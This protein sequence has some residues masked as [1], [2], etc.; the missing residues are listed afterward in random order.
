MNASFNTISQIP[1]ELPLRLPHLS[2][3]D[4]SY[5][6]I[7]CLPESFGLLLHLKILNIKHNKLQG[8]PES[9]VNLIKL[10]KMDLSH[11]H[12]Q[13]L[14]ENLGDLE[15][16]TKINFSENKLSTLP[17]SLCSCKYLSVI[18]TRNNELQDPPQSVCD[19][20]SEATINYMKK[21]CIAKGLKPQKKKSVLNEFPRLRGNQLSSSVPNPHSAH[22]QYIQ[23]QTNTTNTPNRIK[24]PLLPPLG[25]SDL[26]ADVLKDRIIGRLSSPFVYLFNTVQR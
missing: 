3:L 25:S 2:F 19:D 23:T 13:T 18:L 24:T 11:N 14:P 16:L 20:G 26:D 21:R 22:I 8:L 15:S 5:N 17:L 1:D 7:T 6:Q 12:I 9:F 4:I 10:E